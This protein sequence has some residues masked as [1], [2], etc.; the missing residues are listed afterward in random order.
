MFFVVTVA[1]AGGRNADIEELVAVVP[2]AFAL[3][4]MVENIMVIV[5]R[6]III[7]IW[8]L[9]GFPVLN[10]VKTRCADI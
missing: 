9:T 2:N 10:L 1:A 7:D 5:P 6:T 3:I 4:I 8:L